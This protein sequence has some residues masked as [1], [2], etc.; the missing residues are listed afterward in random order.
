[1]SNRTT[2]TYKAVIEYIE[3]N[4]FR[5]EPA[6]LMTDWELGMRNALKICYPHSV[7][8][9]CWFHYC[10]SLRKKF[11]ALGLN[12]L[13]K[14]DECAK[15][16]SRHFMS[17]PLLP[18]EHF[19]TGLNYIKRLLPGYQLSAAFRNFLAYFNFW[20]RQVGRYT[21][22]QTLYPNLFELNGDEFSLFQC[23][24]SL[25]L[26][27]IHWNLFSLLISIYRMKTMPFQFLTWIC[28]QLRHLN[29]WIQC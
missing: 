1:M 25:H 15:N 16:I 3:E 4:V 17:L 29:Q 24:K 28:A 8:R 19:Q 10:N 2:E 26:Y 7:L 6:S 18:R 21:C 27:S 23:L 11:I 20:V 5:L 14:A 12:D 22:Y 13:L 9:G